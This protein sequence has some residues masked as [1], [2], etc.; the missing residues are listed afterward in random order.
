MPTHWVVKDLQ[1]T[2]CLLKGTSDEDHWLLWHVAGICCLVVQQAFH[3][4]H[5]RS[6]EEPRV[7]N[8]RIPLGIWLW[9]LEASSLTDLLLT[10]S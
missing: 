7:P 1:R 9:G 4:S 8:D 3:C 2:Q 10:C 6:S 5:E